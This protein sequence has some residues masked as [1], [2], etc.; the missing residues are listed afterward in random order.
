ML[1]ITS[2]EYSTAHMNEVP[3]YRQQHIPLHWPNDDVMRQSLRR[4]CGDF[5]YSIIK[6]YRTH[7]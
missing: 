3:K 2:K 5:L 6:D 1:S 7:E 4:P